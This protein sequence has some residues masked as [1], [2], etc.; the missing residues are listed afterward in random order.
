MRKP[1]IAAALL[2]S[3]ALCLTVAF[4]SGGDAANPLISLSYLQSIF[5]PQAETQI[6]QKLDQADSTLQG[7]LDQQITGMKTDVL[8]ALGLN[9]ALSA[10]E[11][12]L[13][14]GDVL[15]GTTGLTVT[16]LAGDIQLTLVEGQV[17][18]AGSRVLFVD[19]GQIL[20]DGTPDQ[21]F[22]HPQ[23]PRTK[24]FLSKVLNCICFYPIYYIIFRLIK[25]SYIFNFYIRF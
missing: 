17:V 19:E 4:A 5:S 8:A 24:D 13:N 12:T 2:L 23:N 9:T 10:Q 11:A 1:L 22:N 18:D 14:Y 16:P 15:S 3:A 21:I 6:E 25:P 7:T 20:E